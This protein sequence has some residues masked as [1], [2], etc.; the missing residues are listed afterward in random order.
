MFTLLPSKNKYKFY[1]KYLEFLSLAFWLTTFLEFFFSFFHFWN[2]KL[3]IHNR[4]RF[5]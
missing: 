5:H 4:E 3:G 1:L 2:F